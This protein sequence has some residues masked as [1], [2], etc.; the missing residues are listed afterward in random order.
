MAGRKVEI[1]KHPPIRRVL[2]SL[3]TFLSKE[4]VGEVDGLAMNFFLSVN[5]LSAKTEPVSAG[6][7]P[8]SKGESN[9][10]DIQVLHTL[11]M[12]PRLRP[13]IPQGC[14]G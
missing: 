6:Q 14:A 8:L 12:C 10:L 1:K 4:G 2:F 9:N 13:S 11:C 7:L 5:P 3:R